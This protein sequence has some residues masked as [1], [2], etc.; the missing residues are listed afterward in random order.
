MMWPVT[1][2]EATDDTP[3]APTAGGTAAPVVPVLLGAAV[4]SCGVGLIFPLLAEFQ[5]TFGFSTAG[6]GLISAATFV[7]SLVAGL[8]LAGLAD[9]GHARFLLVAGLVGT[10]GSLV[11]FSLGTELWQF[12]AARGLEG[13]AAGVFVPAARKVVTSGDPLGAGRRL[14][15]LTSAEL[16]GFM[17][18]PVAG[19]A[20]SGFG[21]QVPF[22][23]VGALAI[24]LAVVLA[25]VRLPPLATAT[26]R[27]SA[28][29]SFHLLRRRR[30][31]GAAL[32]SLALFL[33]VGIYDAMWSRYL[34]DRGAS[35]FLIGLGLSLYAVPVIVFAPWGGRLAD[36][37]GAVR[38]ATVA[39]C[40][41]VPLTVGYGFL[42][43][44]VLITVLAVV[45][46]VPQAI[47]NPAVQAAMLDACEAD[48]VAAGQGLA[49]SVNQ[50]GAGGAALLGPLVYAASGPEVLFAGVGLL[51]G[52]VFAAGAWLSR[53]AVP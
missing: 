45:E 17:L 32:L 21:L 49:Y 31:A 29:E 27:R 12:V 48:E 35:T 41:V 30:A 13:L 33:P 2:P 7:A 40:A 6:L 19:A 51:M 14:G 11:W 15:L 43:V 3:P 28:F 5:D 42:T 10:A 50:V 52:A 37:Y 46:G 25:T 8:L 16:A 1:T 26:E 44:P 24:A 4:I 23:V 34:T 9:R 47:A 39:L 53:P 36:R 18:G 22:V 38:V 20:L